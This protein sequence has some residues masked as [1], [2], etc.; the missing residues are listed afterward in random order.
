MSVYLALF[1]M[2]GELARRRYQIAER[3]FAALNLNHTEARLLTLLREEGGEATQE[4]LSNKLTVDRTNAGR[5]LQRLEQGGY[6]LRQKNDTDK[7]AN[8]IQMTVKGR[9]TVVAIL[10][11]R[12]KIAE[13]FFGD[14]DEREAEVILRLLGKTGAG[15][16]NTRSR[17]G[18]ASGS[19]S[20]SDR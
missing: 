18:S 10:R 14:L 16:S 7:R 1:D 6:I 3:S 13:R 15:E 11:L 8:L 17:S 12:Q 4:G 5:A 19:A 2:I 9:K 20:Q